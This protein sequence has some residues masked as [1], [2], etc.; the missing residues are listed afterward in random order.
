MKTQMR[1]VFVV[2]ALSI[3]LCLIVSFWFTPHAAGS[4]YPNKPISIVIGVPPGG[5]TDMAA[6]VLAQFME[7]Q[8]KQP[9]VIV[10]KPGAAGTIGGYAVV[11]AKPDGYK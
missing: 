10:N 11:S 7:K 8:L 6:R 9:V 3:E 2:C 5:S 1:K 4:D